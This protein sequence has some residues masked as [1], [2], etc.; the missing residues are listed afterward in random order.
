V[1]VY[2][3]L[4]LRILAIAHSSSLP[5]D[6]L[7]SG[8]IE[9]KGYEA[10]TMNFEF[11]DE[12]NLITKFFQSTPDGSLENYRHNEKLTVMRTAEDGNDVSRYCS[13][14]FKKNRCM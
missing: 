6:Y 11:P 3:V 10:R 13:C 8:H 7:A 14:V 5:R 1:F 12:P 9:E 2:V 4:S